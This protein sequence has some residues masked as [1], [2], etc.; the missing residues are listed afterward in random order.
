[1]AWIKGNEKSII[2]YII[3]AGI[4]FLIVT[5]FN[6]IVSVLGNILSI[7][8][9][10]IL[11]AIIAFVIN[12]PMKAIENNLFKHIEH[13]RLK[14]I[15]RPISIFLSFLIIILIIFLVIYLVVPQLIG[16]IYQLFE[17]LPK[18]IGQIQ[19]W[20]TQ[21]RET[22]PQLYNFIESEN[23]DLSNLTESTIV[24]INSFGT[25]IL[26]SAL[27]TVGSFVTFIINFILSLMVALFILMSKEEIQKQMMILSDTY[28]TEEK[29]NQIM[30][31][32]RVFKN[33]FE[34]FLVGEMIS[35]TILGGLVTVGMLIFQFPYATMIGVLT[36]VTSL[37]PYVGAYLSGVIGFLLI[38][39]HSPVEAFAFSIFIIIIQQLEGNVIYPR[40]VG[41][42]IG[43]PG[44][45]VI[46]AITLGG[47]LM[48][49]AGMLLFVPLFSAIFKIIRF[50]IDYRRNNR[51]ITPSE[52]MAIVENN[53]PDLLT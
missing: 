53:D 30:Y 21:Y 52:K 42:S 11:G 50:D 47:G 31:I 49:I 24:W 26:S 46:I 27:S 18:L 51:S 36:G 6:W 14:S 1:M 7:L 19:S 34:Q 37:I 15:A 4:V 38:F 12:L 29:H 13:H 41:N 39:V 10:I 9:P 20:L 43:L 22:F 25:N 23:L 2:K 17:V 32:G 28:L 33:S 16:V 5:N 45:W 44:L 35:A 3:V 40:V 8:S 48:G